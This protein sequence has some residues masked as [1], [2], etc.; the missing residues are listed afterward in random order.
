MNVIYNNAK[1]TDSIMRNRVHKAG[2]GLP[3][4]F[5]GGDGVIWY[6]LWGFSCS[7]M[8]KGGK[9]CI[10]QIVGKS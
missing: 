2:T 6:R 1:D 5:I 7:I 10:V 8:I 3:T 4:Y 9:K